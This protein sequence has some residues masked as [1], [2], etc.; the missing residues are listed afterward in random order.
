M[1]RGQLEVGAGRGD[2]PDLHHV[3]DEVGTGEGGP[4]VE[5]G[6]HRDRAAGSL[7]EL[8][9]RALGDVETALVDVV[10]GQVERAEVVGPEEVGDQSAGEDDAACA[11]ERYSGHG[12]DRGA[13]TPSAQPFL[14]EWW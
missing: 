7:A 1:A 13:S 12:T 11:Q 14:S 8:S 5:G 2:A 4:A 3:D 6:L 10:E 9:G